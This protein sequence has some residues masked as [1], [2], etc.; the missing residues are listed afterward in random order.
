METN[1]TEAV[2]LTLSQMNMTINGS[3]NGTPIDLNLYGSFSAIPIPYIDLIFQLILVD[4]ILLLVILV[5]LF[6]ILIRR[7]SVML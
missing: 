6:L 2:N 1:L 5:I 7:K 4:S 3:M